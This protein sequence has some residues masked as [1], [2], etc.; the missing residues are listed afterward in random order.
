VTET[1]RPGQDPEAG[2]AVKV[3]TPTERVTGGEMLDDERGDFVRL[4][5]LS[6]R[7]AEQHYKLSAF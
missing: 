5:N 4:W 7:S 2:E 1:V 3:F 6:G